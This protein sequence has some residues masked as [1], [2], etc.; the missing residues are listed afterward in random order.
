MTVHY[1]LLIELLKGLY[2]SSFALGLAHRKYVV[3]IS[4]LKPKHKS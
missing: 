3:N 2:K 1:A 4:I